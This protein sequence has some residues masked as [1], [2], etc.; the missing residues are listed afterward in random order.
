MVKEKGIFGQN[1]M[2]KGQ[3]GFCTH[4]RWRG[5]PEDFEVKEVKGRNS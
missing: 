2:V 1:R 5:E 3:R 4:C